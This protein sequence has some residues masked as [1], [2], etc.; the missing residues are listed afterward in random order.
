M[1]INF[2]A[3]LNDH[4]YFTK[5]ACVAVATSSKE[6]RP[7]SWRCWFV[8]FSFVLQSPL[9]AT[10]TT[11]DCC[12]LG[13]GS[14][15]IKRVSRPWPVVHTIWLTG[16]TRHFKQNFWTKWFECKKLKKVDDLC[17][18]L[19][20]SRH[21]VDWMSQ[22]FNCILHVTESRR[23]TSRVANISFLYIASL[24]Q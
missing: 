23:H 18:Y 10:V 12:K 16:S 7:R 1:L 15:E 21:I 6:K 5:E 3:A 19:L 8:L 9:G 4:F 2:N 17:S 11:N 20:F 13:V 14:W 24:I 22:R